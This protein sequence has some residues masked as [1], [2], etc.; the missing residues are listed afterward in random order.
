MASAMSARADSLCSCTGMSSPSSSSSTLPPSTSLCFFFSAFFSR[1]ALTISAELKCA[2]SDESSPSLPDLSCLISQ[3]RCMSPAAS[4]C[5][6]ISCSASVISRTS[7]PETG[8][9]VVA[10]RMI[11]C[12]RLMSY[13]SSPKETRG[14]KSCTRLP[15]SWKR[16]K[17]PT[18]RW[19]EAKRVS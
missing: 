6:F 13:R 8:E 3:P 7:M 1:I 19:S 2:C 11:D 14:Q 17:K 9:A 18:I 10:M 16:T 5:D 12:V 4:R 15:I